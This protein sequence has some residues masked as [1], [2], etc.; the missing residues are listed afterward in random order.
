MRTGS[1]W[2]LF[3]LQYNSWEVEEEV[4]HPRSTHGAIGALDIQSWAT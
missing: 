4:G 1:Q 2:N 3:R